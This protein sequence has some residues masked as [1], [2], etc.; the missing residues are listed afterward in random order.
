VSLL[1]GP[2]VLTLYPEVRATDGDGNPVRRPDLAHPVTVT[3]RM[4]PAGSGEDATDGQAVTT[5]YRFT[6]RAFPAGAWARAEW[7]G[8]RWDVDGEPVRR[9]GSPRTAHV[10][11]AL[12][13]RAPEGI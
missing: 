6:C 11:V 10:T 4:Q 3:G 1:D 5:A 7:G 8:R 9:A 13:A 2:D 12:S